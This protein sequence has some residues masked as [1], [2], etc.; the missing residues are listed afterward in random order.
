MI[1]PNEAVAL[2]L[3]II[4]ILDVTPRTF[5]SLFYDTGVLIATIL[6]VISLLGIWWSNY[7]QTRNLKYSIEA[8]MRRDER[9]KEREVRAGLISIL[10][11]F[12]EAILLFDNETADMREKAIM[13]IA[14]NIHPGGRAISYHREAEQLYVKLNNYIHDNLL[15]FPDYTLIN[16]ISDQWLEAGKDY[17]I[18]HDELDGVLIIT[19]NEI[20]EENKVP[21]SHFLAN[22]IEKLRTDPSIVKIPDYSKKI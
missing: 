2:S 22:Q 19:L 12:L 9:K 20:K 4:Q 7:N 5:P 17:E 8:E 13:S 3:D 10:S 14:E 16:S 1:I 15:F 6:G 11:R 21:F 18:E